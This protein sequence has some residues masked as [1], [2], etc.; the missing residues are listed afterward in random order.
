MNKEQSVYNKLHKF[1]A[2]EVELSAQEPMKVELGVIDNIKSASA[3]LEKA[4][5]T[6]DGEFNA[7][8][9]N[10][11]DTLKDSKSKIGNII[12]SIDGKL[13]AYDN[14]SMPLYDSL[15]AFQKAAKELGMNPNE[16]PIYK[17]GVKTDE[18]SASYRK[19]YEGEVKK[20]NA[21]YNSLKTSI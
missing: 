12:D 6:V 2:K 19:Y 8:I 13:N 4:S 10:I 20:L 7:A 14:A 18:D 9:K 16:N 3:K 17:E 21:L 11:Q 15:T 5:G 1:S